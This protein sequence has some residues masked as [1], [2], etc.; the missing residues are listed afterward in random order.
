MEIVIV[1]A[2]IIFLII[3]YRFFS[4]N[5]KSLDSIRNEI[6]HLRQDINRLNDKIDIRQ[7]VQT[8]PTEPVTKKI[9][10]KPLFIPAP[11]KIIASEEIKL[12]RVQPPVEKVVEEEKQ[13]PVHMAAEKTVQQN[14][15]PQTKRSWFDQWLHDNPDIEKFIGENLIN[16]IGI[17]I[18][19]LGIA[20]FVKYA[21][22]QE[23]INKVGRVCI[24]L[25][26]GG[27]L[28]GLAHRLRKN[29]HSFSSVLVGGGLAV[30]YFTIAFAYHQYHLIE[31]T[32]AFVI[33]I[34]ITVFAVILSVLY[35][36]IELGIIATIGGFIT[37]FLVSN[38]EGNYIALFTYL[39][40]L[41]AGLI[42]LAYYKRWRVLNFLA[43]FFT[44][45]I[46]IGWI[47][48]KIDD[49][50]FPYR[51]TFIF[52]AVFYLM[53]V[54]MNVIHHVVRNSKL[55]AFDFIILLSVNLFFYA[56]GLYLL[57][58]WNGGLYKGLFTASLG[59][60]NLALAYLF[61]KKSKA[62]K[63]FIYLLIAITLTFISL[64][65]PIQ[66]KGHHITLFWAAEIVA[67]LWL[68]QK[69]FIKLFKYAFLLVTALMLVSLIWDWGEIYGNSNS[70]FPI[71][72]NKGF[73]TGI[74]SATSMLVCYFLL[75][76][77][78]DSYF[79]KGYTNKIIRR[80]Y[81]TTALILFLA[82][83]ALEVYV[84]F[85]KRIANSG[86]E[87]VYL[88]LYVA[89]FALILFFALQKIKYKVE[90]IVLLLLPFLTFV[91]YVFNLYNTYTTE[92]YLLNANSN[93]GYFVANWISVILIL[94]LAFETIQYIR[95]N[96]EV[97]ARVLPV[98]SW[99][100]CT[101]IITLISFEIMHLF[102]WINYTNAD[103]VPKIETMYSKAG[104]SIVWG[105]SSF[106][107]MWLGM[108]NRYKPL[109]II[110]LV[111]FGITLVKLFVYDI[112]NIAPAGKIVAFILLGVLLLIVSFM[113]QRLK[114]IIIDD[115]R[116]P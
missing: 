77:E 58:S 91:L 111:V 99:M 37:P 57:Q 42:V 21:I 86:F 76:K 22:D 109:R 110:A 64:T 33:M 54:L 95:K 28:I 71:V 46:Y 106:I 29:Y 112:R 98:Y 115:V 96:K 45:I 3:I 80:S 18:L 13:E 48:D 9:E 4:A 93:K 65:A 102:L 1:L 11:E 8:K 50:N 44:Q 104:L 81:L 72:F 113:Y 47:V 75:R 70:I 38:G 74:F 5:E 60:I 35:D 27:I 7:P 101:A 2:L 97:L 78:A 89:A 26:C 19:V 83:G 52:G 23:W 32:P 36:R 17:A 79:L 6:Y 34:V 105:I 49:S 15:A 90:H 39:A 30:F 107:I 67:L 43:F 61:F 10:E 12:E 94:L 68:Y 108:S 14:I 82:V 73:V 66:L 88:Q 69:S 103:S 31:Q 116:N 114:K 40:I 87:F 24:G 25:L 84:Q 53:F 63:N 16:K 20:F 100:I 51:N 92:I 41:N 56:S 59:V 85:N 62:D 55:K